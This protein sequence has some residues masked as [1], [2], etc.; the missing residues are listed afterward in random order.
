MLGVYGYVGHYPL[1]VDKP[2]NYSGYDEFNQLGV[3]GNY[4]RKEGA[5]VGS[6]YSGKNEFSRINDTAAP[7]DS[8]TAVDQKSLGFYGELQLYALHPRVQPYFRWDFWDVNTDL[9]DN[10]VSGPL[11]GVSWRALD[12]GRLVVHYQQL[13]TKKGAS[14]EEKRTSLVF[15]ANFMF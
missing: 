15:E 13:T 8:L 1:S 10:E 2:A 6:L 12:N 7:F 9:G 4:S 5:L 11:V 14:S 3:L